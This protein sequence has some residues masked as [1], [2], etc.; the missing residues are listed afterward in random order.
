MF[1]I[2][3]LARLLLSGIFLV[4]GVSAWQRAPKLR[5][6]A[7]RFSKPLAKATGLPIGG[8]ELIRLNAGVQVAAGGLLAIG[9]QQRMM[10][11]ILAGTLVPTTLAGHPYWEFDDDVDR[12]QQMTH[13]LKNVAVVGG[14]TFAA[15]DTGGRPSVFWSG[16]K[17]AAGLADSVVATTH[18]LTDTVTSD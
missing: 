9:F 6:K 17:A 11:M 2:R 15:L 7:E 12:T 5:A 18:S 14:L 1:G 13:F 16:R 4:G 10:A 3:G 8:E